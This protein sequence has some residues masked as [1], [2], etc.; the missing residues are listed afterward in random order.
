M[1]LVFGDNAVIDK[2]A[3][4]FEGAFIVPEGGPCLLLRT[5]TL[6]KSVGLR[7]A[8]HAIEEDAGCLLLNTIVL[9]LRPHQFAVETIPKSGGVRVG[10]LYMKST[11][12]VVER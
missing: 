2:G 3:E 4:S 12:N 9:G 8:I 5:H 1:R 10:H 7:D 6:V 11:V